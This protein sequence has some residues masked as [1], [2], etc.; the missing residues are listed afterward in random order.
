M[1]E[2]AA[3]AAEEAAPMAEEAAPV[4]EESASAMEEAAPVADESATVEEMSAATDETPAEMES[5]S[6]ETSVDQVWADDASAMTGAPADEATNGAE[7]T[8]TEEAQTESAVDEAPHH[9]ALGDFASKHL[10]GLFGHSEDT[11]EETTATE[12]EG[13]L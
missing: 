4:T 9:S 8:A 7:M 11:A 5:V 12:Q 13:L 3:P 1:A 2:E 6:E 10:G